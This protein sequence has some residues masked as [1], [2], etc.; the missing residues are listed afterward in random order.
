MK[1][2]GERTINKRVGTTRVTSPATAPRPTAAKRPL[3]SNPLPGSGSASS[4]VPT[5]TVCGTTWHTTP[6]LLPL[7]GP[8][9]QIFG[10]ISESFF[11]KK[12]YLKCVFFCNNGGLFSTQNTSTLCKIQFDF[13]KNCPYDSN[14]IFYSYSTPY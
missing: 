6:P 12:S 9:S 1:G 4:P 7:V 10:K 8:V 13:L 5:S 3:P 14:E 11:R 2:R